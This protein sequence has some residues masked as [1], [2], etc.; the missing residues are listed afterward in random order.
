[1]GW[2]CFGGGWVGGL[3][4]R[5]LPS[6]NLLAGGKEGLNEANDPTAITAER[7]T[8]NIGIPVWNEWK[9][10]RLGGGGAGIAKARLVFLPDNWSSSNSIV[11]I[12]VLS[13]LKNKSLKN[14]LQ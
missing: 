1:M 7:S 12:H 3:L 10:L 14:W 8:L 13:P 5:G 6:A 2:C 11:I 9:W 4:L